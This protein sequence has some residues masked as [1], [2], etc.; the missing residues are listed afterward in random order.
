MY[1]VYVFIHLALGNTYVRKSFTL[2]TFFIER[3]QNLE[4]QSTTFHCAKG[5]TGL[6]L[7]NQKKTLKSIRIRNKKIA[8]SLTMTNG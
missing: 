4:L 2:Q 3:T 1:T 6:I 5:T 7:S 8:H